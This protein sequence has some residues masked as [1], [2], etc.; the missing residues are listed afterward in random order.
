MLQKANVQVCLW[1]NST[2]LKTCKTTYYVLFTNTETRR[3]NINT[4]MVMITL[5]LLQWLILRKELREMD[6]GEDTWPHLSL[7]S[8]CLKKSKAN[9]VKRLIFAKLVVL[10]V[11]LQS[12]VGTK[13]YILK[14]LA[15][16]LKYLIIYSKIKFQECKL[17]YQ[18]RSRTDRYPCITDTVLYHD[19]HWIRQVDQVCLTNEWNR[20]QGLGKFCPS[21][22]TQLLSESR[23]WTLG[24]FWTSKSFQVLFLKM[25]KVSLLRSF[26]SLLANLTR[27]LFIKVPFSEAFICPNWSIPFQLGHSHPLTWLHCSPGTCTT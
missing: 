15:V 13:Q 19:E 4:R 6:W 24:L 5:N 7:Y 2:Y 18:V 26:H 11:R 17:R 25:R 22:V 21:K 20:A 9:G 27:F 10:Y 16:H 1:Y 3:K 23:I 14:Y 12:L 8:F